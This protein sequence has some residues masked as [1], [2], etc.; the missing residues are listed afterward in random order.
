MSVQETVVQRGGQQRLN[1]VVVSHREKEEEEDNEEKMREGRYVTAFMTKNQKGSMTH[2][3]FVLTQTIFTTLWR[4]H[5]RLM[6]LSFHSCNENVG[7]II[8]RLGL[9]ERSLGVKPCAW[10]SVPI[11]P[12]NLGDVMLL[13]AASANQWR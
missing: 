8:A 3:R 13:F 10:G 2:C 7:P 1:N 4:Q 6:I 9:Q 12:Y 11:G 5:L